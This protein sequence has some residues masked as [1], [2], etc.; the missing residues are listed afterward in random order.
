MW[1]TIHTT[2]RGCERALLG[3]NTSTSCVVCCGRGWR[4][5]VRRGGA[6]ADGAPVEIDCPV[7]AVGGTMIDIGRAAGAAVM[8]GGDFRKQVNLRNLAKMGKNLRRREP[9]PQNRTAITERAPSPETAPK[10]FTHPPILVTKSMFG[11]AL[12]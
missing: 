8:A 10:F 2:R 11:A 3:R 12:C 9:I 4:G 5:R 6:V 1:D 7:T